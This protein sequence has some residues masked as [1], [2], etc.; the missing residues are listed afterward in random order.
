M[1]NQRPLVYGWK[2]Y[3]NDN[4][5]LPQFN[6]KNFNEN[7]FGEIEQDRLIKFTLCPFTKELS[8]GINNNGGNVVSIPFLPTYEVRL[9][10]NKRL[11]YYRDVFISQEEYHLCRKCGKEYPFDKKTI[12]MV[13][14][15]QTSPIC[16]KCGAHDLFICKSDTCQEIH[17]R[18][19]DSK[20]GMC[21]KCGT[22]L[23]REIITSGQYHREKRWITYYL[24]FQV[25]INGN[26]HKVMLKI[27][28]HGDSELI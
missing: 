12:K 7:S 10:S 6:P 11:I 2:A 22:H 18:Y 20:F 3:F 17:Q 26:N 21:R 4:T 23:R 28:E 15:E 24:G 5:S 1:N 19:E 9:E 16:P 13:D 27:S 25:L 8:I 14:S